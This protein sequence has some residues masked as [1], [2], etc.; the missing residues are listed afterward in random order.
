MKCKPCRVTYEGQRYQISA[1]GIVYPCEYLAPSGTW[2][3]HAAAD[4]DLARA[5]R[6]EASRQRRNRSNRERYDAM[7][8]IG[9]VKTA[10]GWE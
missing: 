7:R 4:S 3:L 6:A 2:Y 5:V 10:Y 9:M 1:D 8:S